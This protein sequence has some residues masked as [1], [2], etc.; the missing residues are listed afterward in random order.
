MTEIDFL[1]ILVIQAR[2]VL[3]SN[4][5]RSNKIEDVVPTTVADPIL[6]AEEEEEPIIEDKDM[7]HTPELNGISE[8]KLETE[9]G[10]DEVEGITFGEEL[11]DDQFFEGNFDFG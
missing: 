9:S 1:E 4:L 2:E 3:E 10:D 11:L 6:V 5:R 7:A 8:P